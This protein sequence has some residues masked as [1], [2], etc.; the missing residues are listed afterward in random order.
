MLFQKIP[1]KDK[2]YSSSYS[3]LINTFKGILTTSFNSYQKD[4]INE[5][6]DEEKILKQTDTFFLQSTSNFYSKI[7]SNNH[8]LNI[9]NLIESERWDQA[10]KTCK[11]YLDESKLS[12]FDSSILNTQL[13]FALSS[14]NK[15]ETISKS[16]EILNDVLIK[17]LA[18]NNQYITTKA[19]LYSSKFFELIGEEK[20]SQELANYALKSYNKNKINCPNLL[21]HILEIYLNNIKKINIKSFQKEYIDSMLALIPSELISDVSDYFTTISNRKLNIIVEE[22][23]SKYSTTTNFL[24]EII[25]FLIMFYTHKSKLIL[26]P[27][28]ISDNY[29]DL[30]KAQNLIEFYKRLNPID[31][32]KIKGDANVSF[33]IGTINVKI[34]EAHLKQTINI[35]YLLAN[36]S[37]LYQSNII[38]EY[39][40]FPNSYSNLVITE[41]LNNFHIKNFSDVFKNL[42][43]LLKKPVSPVSELTLLYTEVDLIL[44]YFSIFGVSNDIQGI[45]LNSL[46]NKYDNF[47][48]KEKAFLGQ[49]RPSER[50]YKLELALSKNKLSS[51][52]KKNK[53]I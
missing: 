11:Y 12:K 16:F 1:F 37:A 14:I 10:F 35:V 4:F 34:I 33:Q 19:I 49:E 24:L 8:L 26:S 48:E 51:I 9:E 32:T 2:Y 45:D 30:I 36:R 43:L 47:I 23:N 18:I 40:L 21:Y 22:Y 29:K 3:S 42:K 7:Y 46:I 50:K 25:W 31:I 41:S 28:R 20:F 5:I 13:S 38:N 52:T 6:N 53:N 44:K 17:S 27:S 39:E 15:D